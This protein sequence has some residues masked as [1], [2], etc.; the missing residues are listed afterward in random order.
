MSDFTQGQLA[1][2]ASSSWGQGPNSTACC[3]RWWMAPPS[4][5]DWR[6][7][8]IKNINDPSIMFHHISPNLPLS[9]QAARRH[10]IESSDLLIQSY[11]TILTFGI[12][13]II[14]SSLSLTSSQ[15]GQISLVILNY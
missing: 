5:P 12:T 8:Y 9:G 11:K 1:S 13:G 4:V 3:F 2:A 14:D 15:S 7:V 6:E 10:C